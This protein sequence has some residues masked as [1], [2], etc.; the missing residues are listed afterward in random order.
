LPA[1]ITSLFLVSFG[2]L[3]LFKTQK[4]AN[5]YVYSISKNDPR[6]PIAL[7]HQIISGFALNS[8]YQ[9]IVTCTNSGLAPWTGTGNSYVSPL[10]PLTGSYDF[11]ITSDYP[12]TVSASNAYGPM[13]DQSEAAY[14]EPTGTSIQYFQLAVPSI[15]TL[16]GSYTLYNMSTDADITSTFTSGS[17][18]QAGY[19][20][21]T[22][23]IP[24]SGTTNN[25]TV[26]YTNKY[27]DISYNY[28]NQ[29][30]QLQRGVLHLDACNSLFNIISDPGECGFYIG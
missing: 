17:S 12:F 29:L 16:T 20:K 4:V 11:T 14:T 30:G 18:L 6:N 28:Y 3:L 1:L 22:A 13:Y 5:L 26:A 27:S 21:V 23:T 10:P 15:V 19:Y 9:I 8:A 24:A 2:F 7:M 25:V